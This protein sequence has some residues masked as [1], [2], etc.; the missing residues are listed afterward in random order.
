MGEHFKSFDDSSHTLVSLM[1]VLEALWTYVPSSTNTTEI[2]DISLYDHAKVT[3]GLANA[4]YLY[5]REHGESDYKTYF[6]KSGT[7]Q[8][9]TS[10]FR[11]VSGELVGI[12][13]F[14]YT[15]S[16]KGAL[17]SLR[18]RAF[19]LDLLV[20][21]I[22]DEILDTLNLNR[23][24]LLHTG[25]GHFYLLVPNL[26][27]TDSQLKALQ[28][29]FNDWFLNNTNVG[30]YLALASTP[31][32]ANQLRGQSKDK[33][34]IGNV[35]TQSSKSIEN[36]KKRP[37][38]QV[39]LMKLFDPRSSLNRVETGSRECAMCKSSYKDDLSNLSD[40]RKENRETSDAELC[41]MCGS[42]YQWG[43]LLVQEGKSFYVIKDGEEDGLPLPTLRTE[44]SLTLHAY[45]KEE[46]K[47]L[48]AGN[49]YRIYVKN[50]QYT[51]SNVET[52][53]W[54]GDYMAKLPYGKPY[55]FE[56]FAQI[57]HG[58]NKL[59]VLR[60]DIDDLTYIFK[61][62]FSGMD[63][64]HQTLSRLATLSRN[65][66]LFFKYYVNTVANMRLNDESES[67]E[68][69]YRLWPKENKSREI[70]I[71]YSSGDELFVVGAWDEVL[72]FSID[73]YKTF[74]RFTGGYLTFSAG[75]AM[76]PPNIPIRTMADVAGTYERTSKKRMGKDS[77]TL[78][79]EFMDDS[80][81]NLS[82]PYM[83]T[84]SWDEFV[85]DVIAKKVEFLRPYI[86]G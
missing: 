6:Y 68:L 10:M 32:T 74:K 39:Q 29:A 37:Y 79:Q 31:W 80:R 56:E 48:G 4:M 73:L 13:N 57:N 65:L 23:C 52:H 64:A 41:H 42:L 70:G 2:A 85:D 75:L 54:I 24:N 63:G 71:V 60:I 12:E 77:I 46:V 28:D 36:A 9:D 38:S 83:H 47:A 27:N 8:R 30:I 1:N 35:F 5:A 16:G 22:V 72:G 66:S 3:A 11:I 61:T 51:G 17:K 25:H 86:V 7:K 84:F 33:I 21:H 14:I 82:N 15:A 26:C 49:A 45:T 18:G 62:A 58:V 67:K 34:T 40:Y 43:E 81:K 20:E 69:A 55:T 59:G 76:V 53:L 50:G 44:T 19:Y 78:F